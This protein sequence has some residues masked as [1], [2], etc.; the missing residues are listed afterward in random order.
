MAYT[1]VVALPACANRTQK[2]AFQASMPQPQRCAPFAALEPTI[3]RQHMA[4]P[5]STASSTCL[6]T[7]LLRTR[8][9]LMCPQPS[10]HLSANIPVPHVD[11]LLVHKPRAPTTGCIRRLQN[12]DLWR[13]PTFDQCTRDTLLTH[14]YPPAFV[15]RTWP[16]RNSTQRFLIPTRCRCSNFGRSHRYAGYTLR[17][18]NR[19]DFL[20]SL[21]PNSLRPGGYRY[22]PVIDHDVAATHRR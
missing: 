5:N 1:S 13:L 19:H 14:P 12:Q 9:F 3:A 17:P 22:L 6:L 20:P 21:A 7:P 15:T 4:I 16:I 10:C 2:R 11:K 18:V 8:T